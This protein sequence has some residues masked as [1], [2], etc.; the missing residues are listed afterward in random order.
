M[1][2]L[3]FSPLHAKTGPNPNA[4]PK[5]LWGNARPS[6]ASPNFLSVLLRHRASRRLSSV[7]DE[8][9]PARAAYQFTGCW[10]IFTPSTTLT[11]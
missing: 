6:C 10:Y 8:G 7:G 5:L 9:E 3:R 1:T 2:T 4:S 11:R